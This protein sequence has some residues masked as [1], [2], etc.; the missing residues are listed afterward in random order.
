MNRLVP[1]ALLT[2]TLS[3]AADEPTGR[4]KQELLPRTSL[5]LAVE[6]MPND[7]P[8]GGLIIRALAPEGAAAKA[9][10]RKGDIIVRVANRA[11]EDFEDL[12]S[13][14][15]GYCCGEKATFTVLRQGRPQKVKVAFG[16]PMKEG[17]KTV[18]QPEGTKSCAFIGACTMPVTELSED[19]RDRFGLD[20]DDGVFVLA[21]VPGS[22]AARVGLRHGDVITAVCGKDIEHPDDLR[23]HVRKCGEGEKVALKVQ[24]GEQSKEIQVSTMKGPCD[25]LICTPSRL[26]QEGGEEASETIEKMEQQIELLKRRVDQ[27]DRKLR[28]LDARRD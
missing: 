17:Q 13:T 9:G 6:E 10:L 14:I 11:V 4:D 18:W 25:V 7:G 16:E 20:K 19:T 23:M 27:L 3:L 15:A 2:L 28:E 8:H 1:V 26:V 12:I 21:V 22:P 5:G 24:R